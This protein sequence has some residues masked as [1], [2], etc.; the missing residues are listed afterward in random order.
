[1]PNGLNGFNAEIEMVS[2][3]PPVPALGPTKMGSGAARLLDCR[4]LNRPFTLRLTLSASS[5]DMRAN[6]D[7]RCDGVSSKLNGE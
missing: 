4:L 6:I 5:K 7:L 1:M 3:S 2:A